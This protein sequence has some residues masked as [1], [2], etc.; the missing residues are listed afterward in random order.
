[1]KEQCIAVCHRVKGTGCCVGGWTG[2]LHF[3]LS[4]KRQGVW[5]RGGYNCVKKKKKSTT[6]I[7][8]VCPPTLVS[9]DRSGRFCSGLGG[10]GSFPAPGLRV[11]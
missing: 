6:K 5:W 1:M 7:T 2:R 9:A 3:V 10:T 11:G 8:S 4:G